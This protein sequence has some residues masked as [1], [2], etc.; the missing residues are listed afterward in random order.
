[1]TQASTPPLTEYKYIVRT[2]GVCGGRPRIDGHRIRVQ[3]ISTL[4]EH[5]GKSADEICSIYPSLTLAQVHA[6]LA[7]YYDHRIEIE[8]E[9]ED[10]VL[11]AE[12]F[13]KDHPDTVRVL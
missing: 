6:A 12:Q 2:P 5:Q 8:K 11:F 9:I 1:M 7:Y 10:G 3:D 4:H 13:T